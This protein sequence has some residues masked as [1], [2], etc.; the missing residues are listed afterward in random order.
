MT[1]PF[2]SASAGKGGTNAV[3][4]V[5]ALQDVL[6]RMGNGSTSSGGGGSMD[7]SSMVAQYRQGPSQTAPQPSRP[8]AKAAAQAADP[9]SRALTQRLTEQALAKA[10]MANQVKPAAPPKPTEAQARSQ[11]PERP[12]SRGDES[13][14]AEQAD[15]STADASDETS[16]QEGSDAAVRRAAFAT[17]QGE[18]VAWVRELTPPASIEP[19]DAV[20]MMNW[21]A[22][23]TQGDLPADAAASL[24]GSEGAGAGAAVDLSGTGTGTGQDAGGLAGWFGGAAARAPSG[25]EA[26]QAAASDDTLELAM[27]AVDEQA[28]VQ[29]TESRT[30]EA[31]L[32]SARPGAF[33][34]VLGEAVGARHSSASLSPAPGSPQ[35]SQALTDQVTVWVGSARADGPMTAELHLNPADMGPINVKIAVDGQLA[36]VDFAATTLETRQAIE[37]S[38]QQLSRALDDVG[39]SLAGGQVMSQFAN[40]GQQGG[41]AAAQSDASRAD[42]ASAESA[43]GEQPAE[44]SDI[45]PVRAGLN[46]LDLYA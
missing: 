1:T 24:A 35:F 27:E 11:G 9:A 5:S 3:S 15:K 17:G 45:R 39:L 29:L 26:L 31:S 38:L 10:R 32:A 6:S 37:A 34:S 8:V 22:Q 20:G 23:L 14:K 28:G 18:G 30:S 44:S 16:S 46:G 2:Q 41:Q 19:G 25:A 33:A 42:A 36:R 4:A 21:L 43:A 12:A 13:R 40:G 7:F